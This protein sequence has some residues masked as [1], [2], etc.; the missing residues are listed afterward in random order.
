VAKF[1]LEPGVINHQCG[2]LVFNIDGTELDELKT[3]MLKTDFF[4]N[5]SDFAIEVKDEFTYNLC[6]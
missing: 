4:D 1:R 3:Q 2:E 5:V 6:A